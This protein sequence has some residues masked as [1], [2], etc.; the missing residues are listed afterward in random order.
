M[1]K[2]SQVIDFAGNY[3]ESIIQLSKHLG[4][5]KTRREIFKLIYGRGTKFRSR[6]QIGT[7][8]G[9]DARPQAVQNALGHL[10]NYHLISKIP[11]DGSVNDGSRFLYGKEASITGHKDKIISF[12][13]NPKKAKSTPTKRSAVITLEKTVR[14][15]AKRDLSKRKALNVLFLTSNPD[16]KSSLRVDV[17][18]ARVQ[19]SIRGSKFRD[20]VNILYKPAANLQ[21]IIDGLNDH[22]PQIVHFSGHGGPSGIVTDK[23]GISGSH[24][25]LLDYDLLA[26]ALAAT[27]YPPSVLVLNSCWSSQGKKSLL[28]SVDHLVSMKVPISDIAAAA[29]APV[30][31]AA[32]A[33]GQSLTAAFRQGLLAVEAASISEAAIPELSSKKGSD[34]NSLFLT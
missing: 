21:T 3:E 31:Y 22:R 6:S 4:K 8:I 33:S 27:D 7:A 9:F 20:S 2:R 16:P 23:G 5:D 15:I 24:T 10:S 17:E 26:K 18:V 13:D 12:A 19:N 32:L 14:S 29:F 30:F 34:P 25:D 1:S 11:N 28:P